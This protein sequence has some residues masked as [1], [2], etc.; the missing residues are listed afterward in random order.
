M[1]KLLKIVAGLVLL[2]I[3]VFGLLIGYVVFFKPGI[4]VEPVKIYPSPARLSRG[5]YLVENVAQCVACH[6]ERDWSLYSGPVVAG[7][8]GK[9]GEAFDQKQGFPGA[10][11]APN[12]TPHHLKDW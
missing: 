11:Y 10:Y 2:V 6:S 12:L 1:K 5:K 4:A 8:D 7:T 9:G 3:V